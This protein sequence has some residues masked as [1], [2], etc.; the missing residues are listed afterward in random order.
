M[1]K[2]QIEVTEKAEAFMNG[3]VSVKNGMLLGIGRSVLSS[4]TSYAVEKQKE[5]TYVVIG[6]VEKTGETIVACVKDLNETERKALESMTVDQRKEYLE[7]KNLLITVVCLA[8]IGTVGILGCKMINALP[9]RVGPF[10]I[11][12]K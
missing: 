11:F 7:K 10:G 2:E 8:G 4:I 6:T 9:R 5:L 12:W 1:R 3:G